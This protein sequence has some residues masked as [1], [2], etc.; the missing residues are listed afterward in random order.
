MKLPRLRLKRR[1]LLWLLLPPAMWALLLAIVPTEW[2]RERLV[3]RLSQA[4]GKKVRLGGLRMGVLGGLRLQDLEIGEPDVVNDAWLRVAD[5][6][7]NLH[8]VNILFGHCTPSR[9]EAEGV[10]LRIHRL[11]DGTL[12]FGSL[13]KPAVAVSTERAPDTQQQL[14]A[15]AS[16]GGGGDGPTKSDGCTIAFEVHKGQVSLIDEPSQT[17]LEFTD[18]D[19]GGTWHPRRAAI[20]RFHSGLNGG[21]IELVAELD[22]T[23]PQAMFEGHAR[24]Y[25]V[26][27]GDGMGALGYLI[28]VLSQARKSVDGKLEMDLYLRGQGANR[29]ELRR[30]LVG[31]GTVTLEPIQ[32]DGSRV[33]SELVSLVNLPRTGSAGSARSEFTIGNNRVTNKEL[34]LTLGQVP[35]VMA[36]WTDFD[37]RVDYRIRNDGLT[38]RLP[39]DARNLL[40][41]LPINLDEILSLRIHGTL[42]DLSVTVD[43][44]PRNPAT[45]DTASRRAEERVRFKEL[46]RRLRD[47]IL[48]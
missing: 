14:T 24:A 23:T 48:K 36:G 22:R 12:E 13:L 33:V 20:E 8:L 41:E 28:P 21:E 11:A 38:K 39:T 6:R 26:A 42:N 16:G 44:P 9:A 32:L 7:I 45:K 10:N 5:L 25:G 1:H 34:T 4:T 15:N 29:D 18:I 37:G 27:F 17:R 47:Q 31:Q 2:A 19:S 46:G 35:F 3:A 30:S 43:G 40:A